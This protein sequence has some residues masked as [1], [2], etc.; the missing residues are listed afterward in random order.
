M[1]GKFELIKT[2]DSQYVFNL[3]DSG[4]QLL[5]ISEPYPQTSDVQK[6][7]ALLRERVKSFANFERKKTDTNKLYFVIRE[8]KGPVIG[9]SQRHASI[10]ALENSITAV[11][12]CAPD[13][14]LVDHTG[15]TG[16]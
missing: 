3:I 12:K 6:A 14:V 2:A 11:H 8:I 9:S 15:T 1:A 16:T 5:F 4:G 10:A 7:I 13:A